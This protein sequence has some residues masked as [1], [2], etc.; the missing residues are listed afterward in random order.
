MKNQRRLRLV[1]DD[2]AATKRVYVLA[3]DAHDFASDVTRLEDKNWVVINGDEDRLIDEIDMRLHLIALCSADAIMLP[4]T[5]WTSVPA[6]QL[7][8]VAGWLGVRFLDEQGVFIESVSM[9]A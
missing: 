2:Y 8:T 5:W 6:H 3:L 9:R 1:T 4:N 7:V